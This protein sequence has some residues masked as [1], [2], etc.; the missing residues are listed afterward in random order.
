M[1][2]QEA[3]TAGENGPNVFEKTYKRAIE[4]LG[5]VYNN[6]YFW[7]VIG[8]GALTTL[9]T[10]MSCYNHKKIET[11]SQQ[12]A[13]GDSILFEKLDN[14]TSISTENQDSLYKIGNRVYALQD[15]AHVIHKRVI[16]VGNKVKG[17]D[18][19]FASL[20]RDMKSQHN[21]QNLSADST[22]RLIESEFDGVDSTIA[23]IGKITGALAESTKVIN[24]NVRKIQAQTNKPK[25]LYNPFSWGR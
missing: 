9:I 14:L 16:G 11:L 8:V 23:S 15:S 7:P 5:N 4:G 13:V 10:V 3:E 25:K 21:M 2:G 19:K 18:S 20:G 6:K 1:V 12:I 22:Y 24:G 17:L